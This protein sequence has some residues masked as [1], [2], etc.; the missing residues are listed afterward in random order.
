MD[1]CTIQMYLRYTVGA[2]RAM[3]ASIEGGNCRDPR[4]LRHRIVGSATFQIAH[5]A[6]AEQVSVFV[7][8]CLCVCVRGG[9][10]VGGWC[11]EL[12]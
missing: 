4:T 1:M 11:M 3:Q 2:R 12:E 8:A 6:G 7:C 10:W 9:G 5:G